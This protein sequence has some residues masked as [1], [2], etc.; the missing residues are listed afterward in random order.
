MTPT[1]H[2]QLATFGAGCFWCTEAIF[3]SLK[4]VAKVVSGYSGGTTPNPTYMSV[5]GGQTGYAEVAQVSFDPAVISYRQLLEVFFL[6]HNP[7]TRNRQGADVGSQY[8]S[9]IFYHTPEQK[10]DADGVKQQLEKDHIFDAP[11]VTDIEPFVSFWP[12]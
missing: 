4:G 10:N 12:A 5:S 1:N 9:V 2:Y 6:T 11:I 7:T 3:T 8:R